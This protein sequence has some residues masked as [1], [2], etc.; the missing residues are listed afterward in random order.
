MAVVLG[1]MGGLNTGPL[2][3]APSPGSPG[4]ATVG[5]SL[6]L[7]SRGFPWSLPGVFPHQIFLR[8]GAAVG[9]PSSYVAALPFRDISPA[10]APPVPFCS[11]SI[12]CIIDEK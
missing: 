4:G 9:I 5:I 3:Y 12:G 6:S 8:G 10:T 11:P 2:C 7:M 1:L